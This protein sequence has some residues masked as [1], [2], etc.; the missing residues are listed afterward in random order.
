MRE[1]R[2]AK[3]RD[4]YAVVIYDDAGKR[5]RYKLNAGNK[6]EAEASANRIIAARAATNQA[7]PAHTVSELMEMYF[8]QGDFLLFRGLRDMQDNVRINVNI[9]IR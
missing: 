2:V 7:R 8:A 1:G 3:Y 5:H 4:G 6:R 9:N